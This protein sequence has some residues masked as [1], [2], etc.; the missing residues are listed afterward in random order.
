MSG[1]GSGKGSGKNGKSG[2]GSGSG[3]QPSDSSS[4]SVTG[5]QVKPFVVTKGA[6]TKMKSK[7]AGLKTSIRDNL[8]KLKDEKTTENDK[9]RHQIEMRK[10]IDK[11]K[12]E[13]LALKSDPDSESLIDAMKGEVDALEAS[14]GLPNGSQPYLHP[15]QQQAIAAAAQVLTNWGSV[16]PG[17]SLNAFEDNVDARARV[18]ACT[19]ERWSPMQI[20]LDKMIKER[21]GHD[22]PK[23]LNA[24]ASF[25]MALHMSV[26]PQYFGLDIPDREAIEANTKK[27]RDL[28]DCIAIVA[29]EECQKD[30]NP[31]YVFAEAALENPTE[32]FKHV[33]GGGFAAGVLKELVGPT[34]MGMASE[35]PGLALSAATYVSNNPLTSFTTFHATKTYIEP[36][37]EQVFRDRFGPLEQQDREIRDLFNQLSE[38][39]QREGVTDIIGFPPAD[40]DSMRNRFSRV[41]HYIGSRAVAATQSM[42]SMVE[43]AMRLP[44]VL[45]RGVVRAGRSIKRLFCD[46]GMRLLHA[47]GFIPDGTE[48][49]M[50]ERILACLGEKRLLEDPEINNYVIA[51]LKLN[52]PSTVFQPLVEMHEA[53]DAAQ[54]RTVFKAGDIS[55]GEMVDLDEESQK[56][57]ADLEVVGPSHGSD[58]L[59]DERVIFAQPFMESSPESGFL[60]GFKQNQLLGRI[61]ASNMAMAARENEEKAAAQSGARPFAQGGNSSFIFPPPGSL[62]GAQGGAQSSS[63]FPSGSSSDRP[64]ARSSSAFAQGGNSAFIF[65]PQ[66]STKPGAQPPGRLGGRSRS[67]KRSV[68]TRTRR[69]GVAKKQNS[70]KNKRQSRRKVHRAS[71]RKGRK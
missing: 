17:V 40:I 21:T 65:P 28:L 43:S 12:T 59:M 57:R 9:K 54:G 20:E 13:L 1:S 10:L 53:N 64:S 23:V 3:K 25:A 22:S 41:L 16:D 18:R 62:P 39:Y 15:V 71:S 35:L 6:I 60:P 4:L 52:N 45:C 29:C 50:F 51:F 24:R 37:L 8:N 32:F 27:V 55:D 47:Y 19:I 36:L 5:V 68:S 34:A 61:K 70:K 67:R 14:I 2:S 38:Y 49:G 42:G 48:E 69:K 56:N 44:E 63:F 7:I 33:L 46:N 31:L 58:V 26:L 30:Y 66:S 11:L